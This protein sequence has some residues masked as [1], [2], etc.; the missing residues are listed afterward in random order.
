MPD[1]KIIAREPLL[2][3]NHAVLG[4]ELAVQDRDAGMHGDD[5][6]LAT[7]AHAAAGLV[8]EEGGWLLGKQRLFLEATPAL[9]ASDTLRK[10]P[11]HAITLSLTMAELADSA[12][13][14]CLASLPS[15]SYGIALRDVGSLLQTDAVAA[16]LAQAHPS[17]KAVT[18]VELDGGAQDIADQAALLRKARPQLNLLA[19]HV[20]TWEKAQDC[21]AAAVPV[22]AGQIYLSPPAAS[23]KSAFTPTQS[24]ILQLMDMVRQEADVRSLEAILKRD[25]AL[26]F[27]LLRYINSVGFGLGTE[28]H[29]VQHAVALLGYATL[30]KWLSLLLAT[31][32]TGTGS[33]VLME[34]AVIRGRFAEL[35]GEGLLPKNELENLFVTGMFSVL[36]KLL[37]MPMETI[38]A[39]IRLPDSVAQALLSGDGIYGPFLALVRA[40]ETHDGQAQNLADEL[41]LS[42]AQVNRA[43]LSALAWSQGLQL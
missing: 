21:L 27:K 2:G 1:E 33:A 24:T 4:Y 36:D 12:T 38:L 41:F 32:M 13:Q 9:L 40:C 31:S 15:P 26:S 14:E 30:Y 5:V 35:L 28:I 16:R 34:T 7:A 39:D 23:R 43:H 25:A 10:L 22:F 37:G 19:R 8:D 18:T 42:P 17:L 3:A 29:S 11:A 6:V 20:S